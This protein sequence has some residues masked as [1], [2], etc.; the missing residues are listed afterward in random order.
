MISF[1]ISGCE[2]MDASTMEMMMSF[3]SGLSGSY[4]GTSFNMSGGQGGSSAQNWGAVGGQLSSMWMSQSENN[5]EG[6]GMTSMLQANQIAYDSSMSYNQKSLSNSS[7]SKNSKTSKDSKSS[8]SS[9]SDDKDQSWLSKGWSKVTN[10]IG[11]MDAQEF[12]KYGKK[13]GKLLKKN[14][15]K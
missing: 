14:Q 13:A 3:M 6:R 4:S 7:S 12:N 5:Q 8:K 9:K 1:S 15:D 10:K 2:G 11:S